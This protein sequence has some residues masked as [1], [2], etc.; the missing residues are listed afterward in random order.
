MSNSEHQRCAIDLQPS[1]QGRHPSD[2]TTVVGC[3]ALTLQT[4]V[5]R[6]TVRVGRHLHA[7][8]TGCSTSASS[9]GSVQ[10]VREYIDKYLRIEGHT[11]GEDYDDD[12]VLI[13]PDG[14][15]VDTWRE[16]YPYDERMPRQDYE[17]SKYLLQVEL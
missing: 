9:L 5:T 17:E 6:R 13:G 15:A 14:R 10:R 2:P 12:P 3:D 16:T 7:L 11:I 8:D 1:S 4:S